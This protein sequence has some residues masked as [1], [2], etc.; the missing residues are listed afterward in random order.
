MN[1]KNYSD[2]EDNY[3][4]EDEEEEFEKDLPAIVRRVL[5]DRTKINHPRRS[6]EDGK[7]IESPD[8]AEQKEQD[9]TIA[10]SDE[11]IDALKDHVKAGLFDPAIYGGYMTVLQVSSWRE[12]V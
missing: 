9:E 10:A 11:V 3:W 7:V 2:D 1:N 4:E 6:L 8:A 12:K 5:D